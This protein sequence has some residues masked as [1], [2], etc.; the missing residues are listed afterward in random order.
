MKYLWILFIF[1]LLAGGCQNKPLFPVEPEIGFLDIQ[2][3]TVREYQDS[4]SI[5]FSFRDGDGDL[6]DIQGGDRFSLIVKDNRTQFP[7]SVRTLQFQI[8][9][10]N[11]NT[12]NPSILGE[13]ILAYPPTIVTPGMSSDSTSYTIF[14]Y[15]QAGHKSNE[16]ITDKVNIVR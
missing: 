3:K 4:I 12:K 10:L 8:P 9:V 7:D 6:G 2:P 14:I 16:I 13:I 5:R 11:T 15:D 1:A